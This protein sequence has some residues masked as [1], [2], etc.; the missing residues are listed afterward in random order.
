MT[1]AEKLSTVPLPIRT[2]FWSDEM[3][4]I[5]LELEEQF[6]LPADELELPRLLFAVEVKDVALDQLERSLAERLGLPAAAASSLY[7]E[8]LRRVFAPLAREFVQFGIGT[9][10][11]AGM[12][13]AAPEIPS[14]GSQPVSPGVVSVSAPSADQ[15][16]IP[17]PVSLYKDTLASQGVVSSSSLG[18]LNTGDVS[19]TITP[20]AAPRPAHIDLGI[21]QSPRKEKEFN[22]IFVERTLPRQATINYGSVAPY[23]VAVPVPIAAAPVHA[24]QT[25][26]VSPQ[27]EVISVPTE[28][29]P[30]GIDGG[31]IGKLMH[32]VAPWHA[33]RFRR[34]RPLPSVDYSDTITASPAP[35]PQPAPVPV[36][37]IPVP[38]APSA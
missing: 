24:E 33:S 30:N 21:P 23:P 15:V 28:P 35:S 14:P 27:I 32:R 37:D 29:A 9:E 2:W 4:Q 22:S 19:V 3:D 11:L 31:L 18:S 16:A 26:L 36:G 38:P 17:Q 8:I 34:G 5:V 13:V 1:N 6:G 7:K 20:S 25:P 12:V 10:E